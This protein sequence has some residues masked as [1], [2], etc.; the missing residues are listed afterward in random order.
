MQLTPLQYLFLYKN[1]QQYTAGEK[2]YCT[3]LLHASLRNQ[4]TTQKWSVLTAI[5][6]HAVPNSLCVF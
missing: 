5:C 1:A 3:S 6:V 2:K 4:K